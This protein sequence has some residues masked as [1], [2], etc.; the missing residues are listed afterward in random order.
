[1]LRDNHISIVE[2]RLKTFIELSP[3]GSFFE[4]LLRSKSFQRLIHHLPAFER[5]G[6]CLLMKTVEDGYLGFSSFDDEVAVS[7]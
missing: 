6:M 3:E 2:I 7:V 5:M 1:M 4:H